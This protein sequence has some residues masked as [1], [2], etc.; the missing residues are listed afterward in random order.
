M[1]RSSRMKAVD[2]VLDK[3]GFKR[4]NL[5]QCSLYLHVQQA[6]KQKNKYDTAKK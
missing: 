4:H 6:R 2:L 5:I 3:N 1:A